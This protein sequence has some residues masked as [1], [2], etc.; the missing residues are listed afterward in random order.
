MNRASFLLLKSYQNATADVK[1]KLKSL[2]ALKEALLNEQTH[3]ASKLLIEEL[4]LN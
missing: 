3:A 1:D 2:I 4:Q